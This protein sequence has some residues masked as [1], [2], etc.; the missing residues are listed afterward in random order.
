MPSKFRRAKSAGAKYS[1]APRS[2]R[3]F[4]TGGS[5]AVRIPRELQF[6]DDDLM[7]AKV[8]E[9]LLITAAPRTHSVREW[10]GSWEADPA[11][12]AGGRRQPAAQARD[13]SA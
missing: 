13:F 10:W 5:V 3:V 1:V 4:R 2:L 9:G 12:M 8:Q 6:A 11:F 7:I